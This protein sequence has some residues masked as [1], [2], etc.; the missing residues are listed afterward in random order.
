MSSYYNPYIGVPLVAWAVAQFAKFIIK[1]ASGDFNWRYLYASG[2]MPSVHSAAICALAVTALAYGGFTSPIFGVA[3]VFAATVIYDSFGVRRASGDQAIAINAILDS[4]RNRRDLDQA[5]LREVLGHRPSEVITGAGLGMVI[6]IA[7][8]INLWDRKLVFLT[9]APIAAERLGYLMI[10]G[11]GLFAATAFKLWF[12]RQHFKVTKSLKQAK[13]FI[14]VSLFSVSGLGLF[15]SL[16]Q[17][18][19]IERGQWRLWS[20]LIIGTAVALYG[21]T[22]YYWLRFIPGRYHQELAAKKRR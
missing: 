5:R 20:L 2:G 19:T 4:L 10:F 14:A 7:M 17:Y 8:T 12:A 13:R 22:W 21:L 9:G 1:A 11:I 16:L 3:A 15:T 18:Q 6:A